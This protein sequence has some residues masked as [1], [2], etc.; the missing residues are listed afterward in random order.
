MKI[1]CLSC[2]FK[3][4]LDDDAYAD[5]EGRAKCCTC[6][7]L[8]QIRTIDGKIKSVELV[9]DNQTPMGDETTGCAA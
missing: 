3:V 2:G 8:L 4:D 1:N 7:G 5:Y 9:E 6:S